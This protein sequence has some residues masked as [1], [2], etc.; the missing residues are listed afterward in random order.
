[1]DVCLTGPSTAEHMDHALEAFQK[2]PLSEDE[3]AWM[4]RV[5]QA[6]NGKYGIVRK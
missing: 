6:I 1:M 3:L 4:R 2:G 5:G